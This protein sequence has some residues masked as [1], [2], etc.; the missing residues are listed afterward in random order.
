MRRRRPE[1]GLPLGLR[2]LGRQPLE[3]AAADVL[4]VA[5]R[6]GRR[7]LLVQEHRDAEPVRHGVGGRARQPH[8]VVHRHTVN[9]HE[10]HDVH[11]AEPWVLAAVLPE[12]DRREAS[13]EQREHGR[14]QRG[15][16]AGE[17]DD[18]AV[19]RGIR[20]PVEQVY[21]RG[22]GDGVDDIADDVG[23]PAFADVR[24]ALNDGHTI[25]F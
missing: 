7:G 1:V 4:E 21:A 13:L 16:V 2:H 12:V 8:A 10:R 20:R 15:G 3:L 17:R 6:G 11:G 19:V 22:G 14:V 25:L 23:T 18:R 9:R 5:P 24:D